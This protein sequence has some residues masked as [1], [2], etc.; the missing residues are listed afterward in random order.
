MAISQWVKAAAVMLL[1]LVAAGISPGPL[2]AQ[3]I[4]KT[5]DENGNVVYTD[6]KPSDDAVPIKLRELTVVDPVELGDENVV[7][8]GTN[9]TG[10]AGGASAASDLGLRIVSPGP[11]ESV[12]NTAYV[13]PVQVN[14]D[15]EL[16]RGA[17]LAY[18]VDGDVQVTTRSTSVEIE[19]IFRGEHQLS[20]ELRSSNGNVMASDG[21][22]TFFMRQHSRLHP[23]PGGA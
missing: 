6:Q 11:E 3:E 16:P 8:R 7:N 5:V 4:Y 20:V 1:V 21:P 22:I 19:E 18:I 17:R 15:R 13:L 12:V 23:N 2:A 9:Q 10:E 14:V